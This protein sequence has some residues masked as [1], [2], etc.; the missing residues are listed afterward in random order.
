MAL[1]TPTSL[2]AGITFDATGTQL[3]GYVAATG[4]YGIINETTGNFQTV[5]DTNTS[6]FGNSG[7][8]AEGIETIA[9]PEP[10]TS[11][12]MLTA[13]LAFVGCRRISSWSEE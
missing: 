4:N 3:Y 9:V 12:L 8:L 10:S 6:V 1:K 2:Y 7:D 5:V 11:V 13:L